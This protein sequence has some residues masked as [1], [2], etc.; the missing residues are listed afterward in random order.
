MLIEVPS[1]VIGAIIGA[2]LTG[3]GFAMTTSKVLVRIDSRLTFVEGQLA[4]LGE[5]RPKGMVHNG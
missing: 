3:F 1:V 5:F 2:L 4:H